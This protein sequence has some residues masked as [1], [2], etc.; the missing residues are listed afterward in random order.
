MARNRNPQAREMADESMVRNLDAQARAIWPQERK[1]VARYKLPARARV[2]DLACGTGEMSMRLARIM[3]GARITGVDIIEA[4][5]ELARKRCR[6]FGRRVQ[7]LNADAFKLPF[8]DRTFDFVVNRHML[9]A[10]PEPERVVAEAVRVLKPGGRVHLLVEDY[11]MMHF[12]PVRTDTDA[13]WRLGPMTYAQRTGTDLKV[14]RKAATWL[15]ELG[16]KDVRVDYAVVDTTRVP[17]ELFAAIWT[18]WR[19]GYTDT[20]AAH[21]SMTRKQVWDGWN[22]MLRAIQSPHGY[23]VWQ[24]PIITGVKTAR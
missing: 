22:D 14:G 12:W 16:M 17:R 9:Q 1:L 20:I 2:L 18:A 11:A 3:P 23:G 5:L 13:F 24:V 4:H 21:S 8:K 19:D 10:V 7:F 6:R 15:H